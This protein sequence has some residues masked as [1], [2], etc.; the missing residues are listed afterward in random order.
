MDQAWPGQVNLQTQV[1]KQLQEEMQP[2]GEG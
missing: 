1:Q 2:L